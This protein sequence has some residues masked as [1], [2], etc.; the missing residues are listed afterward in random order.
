MTTRE[1]LDSVQVHNWRD[2]GPAYEAH[3]VDG[4]PEV[5]LPDAQLVV[6]AET[7]YGEVF[8]FTRTWRDD[9]AGDAR[10][11]RFADR[12]RAAGSIDPML[13]SFWRNSYGSQAYLDEVA[14]MTREELAA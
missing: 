13:W 7:T 1:K 9:D 10:A 6:V 2:V 14:G 11:S 12:V 4:I 3:D 5:R 8:T